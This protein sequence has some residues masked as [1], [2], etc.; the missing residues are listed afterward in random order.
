M[1]AREILPPWEAIDEL[2]SIYRGKKIPWPI[3]FQ[4]L[5]EIITR[6]YGK[7]PQI[8]DIGSESTEKEAV[9]KIAVVVAALLAEQQTD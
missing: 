8:V 1:A 9:N 3:K 4:A 7:A 6:A 5:M 2:W